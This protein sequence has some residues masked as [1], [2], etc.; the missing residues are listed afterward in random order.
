MNAFT[1][2]EQLIEQFNVFVAEW[3]LKRANGNGPQCN[4]A[5]QQ[6]LRNLYLL[7]LNGDP[8]EKIDESISKLKM[9][10]LFYPESEK[11][12]SED[13]AIDLPKRYDGDRCQCIIESWP[14]KAANGNMMGFASCIS[15]V[16][17]YLYRLEE[18]GDA[19]QQIGK[20]LW[21]LNR[22]RSYY[23]PGTT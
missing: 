19:R 18:K 11:V 22:I 1:T 8:I 2:K 23:G 7:E 9:V 15:S 4:Q 3:P 13:E 20:A 6:V 12:F 10:T 14:L 5:I 17:R 21:Y 16:L